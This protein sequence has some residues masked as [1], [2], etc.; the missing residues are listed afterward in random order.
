MTSHHEARPS[1]GTSATTK[2]ASSIG[3]IAAIVIAL[4]ANVYVSRHYARWD[5]TRGG[6]YTLSAPTLTTLHDLE[7]PIQVHVLLG[8]D[9]PLTL[10]LRHLLDAYRAEST[11]ID[12][13]YTDPD[14]RPAEFL[15]VQQRYGVVAGKTE[16]GRIITDAAVIVVRAGKPYFITSD[17]FVQVDDEDDM[18]ARP[19]LEQALT[20]A[21]RTLLSA[22]RPVACFATGHGERSVQE[23]GSD[24][25]SPLRDRLTKNNFDV[26]ELR[27]A[28]GTAEGTTKLDDCRVL[29]VAGPSEPFA[30]ED[31]ATLRSYIERGGNALIAAGPVP[32]ASGEGYVDLGL[33]GVLELAGVR[34]DRDFVFERSA[35]YRSTQGFGETFMPIAKPHS[36]TNGLV[37]EADSGVGV[38]MTV[39]SSLATAGTGAAAVPVLVTSDEA[40]GMVDFFGW[41]KDPAP[42]TPTDADKKGPLTV[43][44]ASELPKLATSDPHGPRVVVA[45]SASVMYGANWQSEELRGTALFV[46]SALAWLAAKPVFL[47]IPNKPM[48]AAGLHLTEDDLAAVFRYAVLLMPLTS[49][50]VGVAVHLRRRRGKR[51]R[52]GGEAST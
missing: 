25:L 29:V 9:D 5:V 21:I 6:L 35:R 45:G 42:P 40:F 13:S 28:K 2:L 38:V 4:L 22:E 26:A 14:R 32:N 8:A 20:A 46:E 52:V 12:V 3:I 7:E 17:D 37:K 10:S 1:R 36:V 30:A 48:Y 33:A 49:I 44:Y 16:D 43:A 39:A 41:A 24:G 47:D 34:L 15:A 19:R 18:R 11:R 50:L 51:R 27:L 31:A 23:G